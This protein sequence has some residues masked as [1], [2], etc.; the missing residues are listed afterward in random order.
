MAYTTPSTQPTGTLITSTMYSAHIINNIKFLHGPP[1]AQVR[2]L[3]SQ[4]ISGSAWTAIS[5]SSKEWD[6]N[7]MFA[8]TGTKIT[9][10]TAGK[11]LATFQHAFMNSAQTGS[12]Y[13][14]ISKNTTGNVDPG[15]GKLTLTKEANGDCFGTV[16]GL[17]SLTT[18]QFLEGK[19]WSNGSSNL[20]KSATGA[21]GPKFAMLWVSS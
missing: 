2:R 5:W 12:L 15:I 1:T 17:F 16:S 8:S 11:Y 14:A 19:I 3:A 6:T 20:L 10:K 18:G 9:C 7:S 21:N 13:M 4:T